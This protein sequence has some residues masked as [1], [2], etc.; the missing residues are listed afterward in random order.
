VIYF[1][2]SAEVELK[3]LIVLIMITLLFIVTV[4]LLKRFEA[5]QSKGIVK[6]SGVK[7]YIHKSVKKELVFIEKQKHLEI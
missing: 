7:K 1:A 5:F 2:P 6:V 4:N 3:I